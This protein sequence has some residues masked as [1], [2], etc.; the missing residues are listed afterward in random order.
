MIKR[1]DSLFELLNDQQTENELKHA[2]SL[3]D[4][5]MTFCTRYGTLKDENVYLAFKLIDEFERMDFDV[6]LFCMD[7]L[8]IAY[9]HSE[10]KMSDNIQLNINVNGFSLQFSKENIEELKQ[11]TRFYWYNSDTKDK[12]NDSEQ[13]KAY[14]G[15]RI[16]DQLYDIF[17][18]DQ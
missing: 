18:N 12:N 4:E 10:L 11:A 13:M 1:H 6:R 17:Y 9:S 2:L 8:P 7:C 3:S 14:R 15:F 5:E 16:I